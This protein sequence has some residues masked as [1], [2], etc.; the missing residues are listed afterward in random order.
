MKSN[1]KIIIP[2]VVILLLILLIIPK[3]DFS[4]KTEENNSASASAG[5]SVQVNAKILKPA[6]LQNKIF[7]NGTLIG[8]EEVQLRS[9]TSG[10]VTQI[11]FKEG[12]RVKKGDLLLKINDA[13]LQATQRKNLLK[14]EFAQ[15]KEFRAKQLIEKQ[16]TSQQ[17]YDFALN[18]LN[19]IRADIEF[20]NAQIAK[21]EIHAPFDGI[22]GLR[23]VSIGSYITPQIPVANLQSINPIKID[24]AIPQKYYSEV[25]EGKEIEF[26]LPST[27]KVF[28]GKI[29]AVE[30]KIDQ[31]TR[32]LL[33][34]AVAS[35][36]NYLL[37]PGAYVEIEIILSNIKDAILVPSE[38]V[39]P[40]IQGEKVFLYKNGIA[41]TKN[42]T[43]GIRNEAD[44]QIISGI[45]Q[46]DTVIV[47][48][49]I[50]LRPN[51]PV[52]LINIE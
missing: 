47:S 14:E 18:E 33:V 9:E 50:Q 27:E 21:T 11:L 52:N 39:V 41:V 43:T 45:A 29:Y 42:V 35:N 49:I 40:D 26:R 2:F 34:R 3:L 12:T 4:T 30:P 20:T 25:K 15:D 37:T 32:T 13:E 24:F 51:S 46:G 8:N 7:T 48:G 22:I 31:T 23:S 19:S 1:K 5:K 16:L 17:D 10:K 28:K 36:N 38:A 6:L 44:I